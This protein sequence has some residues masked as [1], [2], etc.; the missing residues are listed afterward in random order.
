MFVFL[1]A[2]RTLEAALWQKKNAFGSAFKKQPLSMQNVFCCMTKKKPSVKA[3]F[4]N[5]CVTESGIGEQNQRWTL[6]T[7][8]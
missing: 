4:E 2:L 1:I 7:Q 6:F 3:A 8:V 5:I